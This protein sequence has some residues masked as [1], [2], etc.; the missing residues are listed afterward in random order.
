MT[1]KEFLSQAFMLHKLINAKEE[2]IQNLRDRQLQLGGAL[3]DVKVQTG[4]AQDPVGEITAV[5]LDLIDECRHDIDK[6]LKVQQE[7]AATIEKVE[8]SDLRLILFER[9]INLKRWEDIAADNN[10]SWRTVHRKHGE[11]L[12]QV[13]IVWHTLD[14]L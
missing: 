14:M 5:L 13:G 2:R 11:A 9:Y 7:I 10:Y 4:P 8:R 1:V 12:A 3:S 6:L